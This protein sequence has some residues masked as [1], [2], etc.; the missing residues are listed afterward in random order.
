M[1]KLSVW[2]SFGFGFLFVG[3]NGGEETDVDTDTLD[4]DISDSDSDSDTDISGPVLATVQGRLYHPDVDGDTDTDSDTDGGASPE[5]IEG[6][7][8]AEYGTTNIDVTDASGAFALEME[9]GTHQLLIE[10]MGYW[11]HLIPV[12]L[13]EGGY[14]FDAM[15]GGNW[16]ASDQFV[17]DVALALPEESI[18]T[19]KGIVFVEFTGHGE[20][21]GESASLDSLD[22]VGAFSMVSDDGPPDIETS[23]TLIAGA[24]FV[25]FYGVTVGNAEV[26]VEG[27]D[28]VNACQ[29]AH[30]SISSLP[31]TAKTFTRVEVD[32]APL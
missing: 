12:T 2:L 25:L 29:I 16:L 4:S 9:V 22:Y 7:S 8:V 17:E 18:D 23:P 32:C 1:K 31:V 20:T 10:K 13:P 26:T 3:C 19:S 11:G 27:V 14:N 28:G 21:G 24:N 30:T 6:A 5:W 15:E